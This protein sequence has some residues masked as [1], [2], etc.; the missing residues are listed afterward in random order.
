[1]VFMVYIKNRLLRRQLD[2]FTRKI[3][4]T[5]SMGFMVFIS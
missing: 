4:F 3:N 5:V 1:M 2:D